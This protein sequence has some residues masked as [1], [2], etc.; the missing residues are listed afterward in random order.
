MLL[1]RDLMVM[2]VGHHMGERDPA[3][4][5]SPFT[6]PTAIEFLDVWKGSNALKGDDSVRFVMDPAIG[7]RE[8]F[9]GSHRKLGR[10]DLQY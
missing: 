8:L 9:V 6:S 3:T 5:T 1:L 7:E 10:Q 4:W 2:V